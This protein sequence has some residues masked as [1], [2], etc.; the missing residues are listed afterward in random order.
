MKLSVGAGLSDVNLSAPFPKPCIICI[1]RRRLVN[2]VVILLLVGS[3]LAAVLWLRS[4]FYSDAVSYCPNGTLVRLDT[5]PGKLRI[6]VAPAWPYPDWVERGW[7]S[8][9]HG[10]EHP[11]PVLGAQSVNRLGFGFEHS[12]ALVVTGEETEAATQPASVS[13]YVLIL[14]FWAMVAGSVLIPI[15]WI[16]RR[17]RQPAKPEEDLV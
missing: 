8:W 2:L 7:R 11:A 5:L 12:Q 15:I 17:R 14:P 4:H 1:M 9:R 13:D 3:V 10:P 16:V 6:E